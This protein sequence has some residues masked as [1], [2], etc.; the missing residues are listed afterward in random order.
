M[1]DLTA[2]AECDILHIAVFNNTA[3]TAGWGISHQPKNEILKQFDAEESHI[4][5]FI[6]DANAE[7]IA[8][9]GRVYADTDFII[10]PPD[11]SFPV[12]RACGTSL[13]TR[14]MRCDPP[15]V[16]RTSFRVGRS[17]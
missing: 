15:A 11:F 12:R 16:P 4:I 3:D 8:P 2:P 10:H 1:G 5:R 17:G 6:N 13:A 14:P 9:E 7:T